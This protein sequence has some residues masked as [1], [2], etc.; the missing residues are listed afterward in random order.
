MP[1]PSVI[2]MKRSSKV[3]RISASQAKDMTQAQIRNSETLIRF[4]YIRRQMAYGAC[5]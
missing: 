4:A 3:Y 5:V 2:A 1:T